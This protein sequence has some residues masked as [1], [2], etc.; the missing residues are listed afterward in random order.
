[1]SIKVTRPISVGWGECANP[2]PG[3]KYSEKIRVPMSS[4]LTEHEVSSPK[5]DDI[6]S[7]LMGKK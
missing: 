4:L 3:F 5:T 1:M 2:P 6:E 7:N